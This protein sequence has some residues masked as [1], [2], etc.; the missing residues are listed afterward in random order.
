[1]YS[2]AAGTVLSAGEQTLSVTFTPTDMTNYTSAAT[3]VTLTVDPLTPTITWATPAAIPYGTALSATELSATAS[4]PGTF[5]YSPAAGTVLSA[6]EQTLSVTFTPTDMTNYGAA[7]AMTTLVVRQVPEI[8]S[9]ATTTFTVGTADTFTV[10]ASGY[11]TPTLTAIGKLPAGVTFDGTTG[12]L[13]GTPAAGTDRVYR[14]RLRA[15]N[16]AGAVSQ[17]FLL[18]VTQAPTI[19]SAA[20]AR[21]AVGIAKT[22]RVR[23]TG[24][25]A[26]TLVEAGALPGGVTFNPMTGTLSGTA[27]G[28]PGVYPIAFT[29]ANVVGVGAVQSFTLTVR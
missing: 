4:A 16:A 2:P 12:V 24:Y 25:P 17:R 29:A 23:A 9:V 19:T 21:F 11:P 26:P 27:T 1:V 8:S 20:A 14:I 22:F 6:G 5:V 10:V 15:T 18:T 28:P 13:S 3:T 7:T